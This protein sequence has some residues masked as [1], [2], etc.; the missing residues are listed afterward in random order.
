[1]PIQVQGPD[2]QIHAFPDGT[3]DDAIHQQ[4]TQRYSGGQQPKPQGGLLEGQPM[5]TPPPQPGRVPSL[6]DQ[7]PAIHAVMP[8]YAKGIM[9]HPAYLQAKKDAEVQQRAATAKQYG[10]DPRSPEGREYILTGHVPKFERNYPAIQKADEAALQ[11]AQSIDKA[12]H[13]ITLNKSSISA[14]PLTGIASTVGGWVGNQSAM[15]TQ[16]YYTI[17]KG[18]SQE[19]AK[20]VSGTRGP[21]VFEQKLQAD[22]NGGLNQ[23]REVRERILKEAVDLLQGRHE[24]AQRQAMEMRNGT[25]FQPGNAPP[26]P[27]RGNPPVQRNGYSV[28]RID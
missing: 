22:L 10:M 24:L 2:G 19:I 3:P 15:D 27:R 7:L 13:A 18:L 14:G 4:M 20:S 12:Q 17:A 6:I 1:M 16:E 11:T 28:E 25:Y 26:V 21:S 8:E 9:E 23:P 5:G